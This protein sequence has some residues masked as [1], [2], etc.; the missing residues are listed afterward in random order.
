MRLI[1]IFLGFVLGIYIAA[2]YPD[3]ATVIFNT[4]VDWFYAAISF[5]QNLLNEAGQ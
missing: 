3:L 4:A 2:E 1:L 5:F